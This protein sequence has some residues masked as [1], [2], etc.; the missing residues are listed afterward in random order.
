MSK[1]EPMPRPD[2]AVTPSVDVNA[3]PGS[4]DIVISRDGKATSHRATG[5][6]TT[7][8]VKDAVR[9]IINDGRTA[10]WLP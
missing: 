4:V 1:R 7:E 5:G 10:E 8:V 9:Q 2:V 6:S 3:P